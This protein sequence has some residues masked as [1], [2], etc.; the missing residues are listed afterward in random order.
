MYQTIRKDLNIESSAIHKTIYEE[1]HMKKLGFSWVLHNLINH[2]ISVRFRLCNE[3]VKLFNDG[4]R[5]L[6]YK[7]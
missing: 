5:R 2:Q 1:I 3:S 4:K 7:I 6:I